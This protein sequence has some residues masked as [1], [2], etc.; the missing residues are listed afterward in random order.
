MTRRSLIGKERLVVERPQAR[1]LQFPI[2]LSV[3]KYIKTLCRLIDEA[4][5]YDQVHKVYSKVTFPI[6]KKVQEQAEKLDKLRIDCMLAAEKG[7]RAF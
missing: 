5:C 7:C 3:I 1:R 6:H 2:P 4:K